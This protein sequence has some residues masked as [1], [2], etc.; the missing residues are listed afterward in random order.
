MLLLQTLWMGC[1]IPSLYLGW[2]K[3]EAEKLFCQIIQASFYKWT[4]VA[5]FQHHVCGRNIGNNTKVLCASFLESWTR[6]ID[7]KQFKQEIIY[8]LIFLHIHGSSVCQD[9]LRKGRTGTGAL[10]LTFPLWDI[11]RSDLEIWQRNSKALG[12][13]IIIV[14]CSS[15]VNASADYFCNKTWR[16]L[17]ERYLPRSERIVHGYDWF[18]KTFNVSPAGLWETWSG[19]N[20]IVDILKSNHQFVQKGRGKKKQ[21]QEHW[22]LLSQWVSQ[23]KLAEKQVL[24]LR[25]SRDVKHLR[26]RFREILTSRVKHCIR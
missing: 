26:Y 12:F 15:K 7:P 18:Q 8:L 19:L 10:L 11:A 20:W 13:Q 17:P 14:F 25:P 23:T 24:T 3:L 22:Y 4:P 9:Y 21:K 5:P 2:P 6:A 1:K 16:V